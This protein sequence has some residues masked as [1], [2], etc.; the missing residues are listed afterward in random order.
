MFLLSQVA[1]IGV[2]DKRL[3]ENI[4]AWIIPDASS[5]SSQ[6]IT[7]DDLFRYFD[8]LYQTDEGLGMTPAYFL[9]LKQFPT[10]N[11]KVDRK[12]LRSM[13]IEELHTEL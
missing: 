5:S 12:A 4:C 7:S 3:G 1:V 9:F 8:E 10:V 2:P 6:P 11:G 13:A